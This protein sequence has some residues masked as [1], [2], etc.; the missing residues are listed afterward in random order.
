MN[1]L[2]ILLNVKQKLFIVGYRIPLYTVSVAGVTETKP[3][4]FKTCPSYDA[5]NCLGN[6]NSVVSIASVSS[7]PHNAAHQLL[8]PTKQ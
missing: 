8:K 6:G 3:S 7:N 2:L 4:V 1:G 5:A